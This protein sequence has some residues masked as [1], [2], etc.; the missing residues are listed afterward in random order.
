MT[1]QVVIL[2]AGFGGLELSARLAEDLVDEVEVTLID[3]SDSFVF[4]FAKLD[5]MFGH[6]SPDEVR[7]HYRDIAKPNVQFRQETVLS[8]DPQ[9]RQVVTDRATYDADILVVALG[10]DLD[11]DATPGLV[12]GGHEFYSPQGAERIAE[13][14]PSFE[15][16]VAVIGVLGPVFKCPPAPSECAL[17]LH[18]YLV[19]RG[20]RDA[21]E[22]SLVMPFG[23]PIPP[24]PEASR[25]STRPRA[26]SQIHAPFLCRIRNSAQY[27]GTVDSR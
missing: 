26:S 24:A 10:A 14:L 23:I 13:L 21:C 1:A 25:A 17:M 27:W 6:R 4:G 15:A 11:S 16:G 19:A 12:E 9:A 20:H 2:G 7:L 3:R 18:D 22:I 8:I 5:V